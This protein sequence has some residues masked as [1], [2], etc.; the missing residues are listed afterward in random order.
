MRPRLPCSFPYT[1]GP[2]G[3]PESSTWNLAQSRKKVQ[4]IA[5]LCKRYILLAPHF[6]VSCGCNVHINEKIVL[7][8]KFSDDLVRDSRTTRRYRM[9]LP[10]ANGPEEPFPFDQIL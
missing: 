5:F 6:S 7:E 10:K 8:N 2:R 3:G 1:T 9:P 4:L